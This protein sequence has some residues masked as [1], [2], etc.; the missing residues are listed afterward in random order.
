MALLA[1]ACLLAEV[2]LTRP[3]GHCSTGPTLLSLLNMRI[4]TKSTKR[5]AYVRPAYRDQLRRKFTEE[6]GIKLDELGGIVIDEVS[7]NELNV[8]GHVDMRLRVLMDNLDVMCGGIPLL[9]CGDNHQK[10]P[11]AGTPWYRSLVQDAVDHGARVAEGPSMAAARGLQLLHA[12]RRVELTTL[13]RVNEGEEKEF[14]GFLK[15]MRDISH[16]QPVSD[17]LLFKLRKVSH[18]LPGSRPVASRLP[19]PPRSPACLQLRLP[20]A[21]SSRR[22][23]PSLS[24]FLFLCCNSEGEH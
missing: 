15:Q 1:V 2:Q 22:A 23:R 13:M 24:L 20:P 17:Q 12:A 18:L 10:P 6:S 3:S 14:A 21:G 19:P 5:V 9:L 7:F 11:P 8:F 16:E 4:D